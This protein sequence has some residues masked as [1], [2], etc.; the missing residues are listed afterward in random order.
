MSTLER[1]LA[2]DSFE[3]ETFDALRAGEAELGGK[4]LIRCTFRNAKL[5]ETAWKRTRLEDCVF[6]S[7][8]LTRAN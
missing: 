3:D 4:E 2:E 7:C 6:D 5:T 8:D 1:L